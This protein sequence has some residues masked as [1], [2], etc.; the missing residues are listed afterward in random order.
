[1]APVTA[2]ECWD[3]A[4]PVAQPAGTSAVLM[5]F[6][7]DTPNPV[8]FADIGA[9][10]ARYRVPVWVRSNPASVSA[11]SDAA[12]MVARL[13]A[14]RVPAG[15][16]TWLDLETAVDP[17]YVN[18]YGTALHAA[19]Y[20]VTPYGSIGFLHLNPQLDGYAVAHYT[21]LPHICT[22]STC[23][24]NAVATQYANSMQT[25]GPFDLS[26]ISSSCVLWDTVGRTTVSLNNCVGMAATSTGKGYWLVQSDG[27]VFTHGDAGFFGSIP[28]TPKVTLAA[29]I[30]GI[31][32]TPSGK[33][34]WLVGEDGGVFT[35]GD[36]TFEGAGA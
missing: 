14:F 16:F 30:V 12:A 20:K 1:M 15:V 21:G 24:I 17:A 4:W 31:V 34:Y 19:G 13:R 3:A 18:V 29:P 36:A 7:G 9:W 8:T 26:L 25:G 5:Y 6:G 32:P 2:V 23:G 33:G 10:T 28:G 22:I 27:G 11:A 35:F